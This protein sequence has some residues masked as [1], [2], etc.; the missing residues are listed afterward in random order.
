[1]R[2]LDLAPGDLGEGNRF[3]YLTDEGLQH[4]QAVGMQMY[5]VCFW[6]LVLGREHGEP[7]FE[8]VGEVVNTNSED[9]TEEV[10]ETLATN[11]WEALDFTEDEFQA[12]TGSDMGYVTF[13]G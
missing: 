1:M 13:D 4:V 9:L 10:S 6:R 12:F 3:I 5:T 11:Q 2:L 8:K 7:I